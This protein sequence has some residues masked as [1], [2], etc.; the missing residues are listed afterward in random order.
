MSLY[1]A[2]EEVL[3]K[4]SLVNDIFIVRSVVST[5]DIGFLPGDEQD[6][7]SIYEAPYRS[8]CGEFFN[9]R[10]AYDSLK[11]QGTIKFM[12]TS[13]IRGITINDSIVIVDECQNLNFHELDSIITRVGR[14]S[15]IIFC[16]D[17]TQTDLTKENDKKGIL[18]FM[19][20]IKH[21]KEFETIEFDIDDIVRSDFLRSYIIAKY[22][23]GLDG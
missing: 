5:R 7:V 14:N 16:G 18:R 1:L 13:F 6:K 10:D 22:K 8:I 21:I 15:R 17:Y 2:L 19:E 3:D 23:L 20:I 9:V 4:S 11:S 12:S